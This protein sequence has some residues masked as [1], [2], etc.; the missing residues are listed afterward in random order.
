MANQPP[1]PPPYGAPY[2]YPPPGPPPPKPGVVPLAPLDV[3]AVFSGVIQTWLRNWKVVLSVSAVAVVVATVLGIP[4]LRELVLLPAASNLPPRRMLDELVPHLQRLAWLFPLYV[5]V[6]SVVQG[7]AGGLFAV[8]A[9]QAVLGRRP[10]WSQVWHEARPQF[11]QLVGLALVFYLVV[12]VGLALC[13]VP[14]V[15]VYTLWSLAI[16]ALMT[17][18]LG[19]G[20]ALSRSYRLVVGDAWRVFAILLLVAIAAQAAAAAVGSPFS[21]A[22]LF[23]VPLDDA[24]SGG[25]AVWGQAIAGT[26]AATVGGLIT[27]AVLPFATLLLYVDQ[28][29]RR[30]RYDLQLAEEAAPPG[31]ERPHQ[32]PH[33]P[34][35]PPAR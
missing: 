32:P 28:R 12:G 14:G 5:I 18:R 15:V 7:V 10:S 23:F 33:Q 11:A 24:A 20:Q 19:I 31:Q 21:A 35:G 3:G 26:A 29:I 9:R 8:I 22:Q 1:G 30:E 17:E 34:P 27:M 16:P 4:F 13:I 2:G 6:W 25:A